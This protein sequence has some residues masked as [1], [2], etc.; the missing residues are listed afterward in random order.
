[1]CDNPPCV[2]PEHLFL[3]SLKDNSRDMVGK[4]RNWHPDNKGAK[5]GRAK[6]N[7]KAVREIRASYQGYYGEFEAEQLAKRF[8]VCSGTIR[9]ILANKTWIERE[10]TPPVGTS[11][12][13]R[14]RPT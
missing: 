5:N 10:Y 4:M 1:M 13:G 14:R 11:R 7:W 2:N 8:G 6:L 3:G 9:R 12:L